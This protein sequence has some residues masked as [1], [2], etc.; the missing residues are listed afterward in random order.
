MSKSKE[1]MGLIIGLV[2]L[3][4]VACFFV[5]GFALHVWHVAWLVFLVIPITAVIAS[6]ATEKKDIAGA[7]TGLVALLCV[8][9]FAL[10]GFRYGL[11]HP[12][13]MVFLLV[14]ITAI[15]GDII[16]GKSDSVIG[17][18]AV[19][20]AIVFLVL[21]FTLHVWYIAWLVFLLI[22]IMAIVRNMVRVARR[23]DDAPDD[24]P[25]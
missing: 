21:G 12:G 16:R 18:V 8:A 15:I 14:P 11:W 25:E 4:C 7:V 9:A 24:K 5:L 23:D 1:M 22:P 19:L 3:L 6:L 10:M 17:L 2:A 20:A 13:W